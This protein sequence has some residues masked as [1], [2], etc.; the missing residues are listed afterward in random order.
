MFGTPM[1]KHKSMFFGLPYWRHLLIHHNL[2]VMNIEKNT[3][4]NIVGI[5]LDIHDKN[6]DSLSARL[7]LVD[8]KVHDKL[9]A[10]LVGDKYEA[11]KVAFN[12]TLSERRQVAAFC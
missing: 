1:E 11:P 12:I 5:L 4:D 9:R 7:D 8:M 6:K 3:C 10:K 2:D